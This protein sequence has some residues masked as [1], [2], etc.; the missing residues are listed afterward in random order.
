MNAF[1]DRYRPWESLLSY[2]GPNSLRQQRYS[3]EMGRYSRQIQ[4]LTPGGLQVLSYQISYCRQ[5]GYLT[6]RKKFRQHLGIY[7]SLY[8]NQVEGSFLSVTSEIKVTEINKTTLK[9]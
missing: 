4:S 7:N 6:S 9:C 5:M 3:R 2:I 8:I 1:S